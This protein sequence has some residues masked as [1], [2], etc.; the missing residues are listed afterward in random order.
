MTSIWIAAED[1]PS[2]K[3]A[4]RMASHA[5]FLP[6]SGIDA[7]G[8]PKLLSRLGRFN[9]SAVSLCWFVLV[10]LDRHPCPVTLVNGLGPQTKPRMV[11]RI[12]MREI[13]SW[14]LAD[15]QHVAEWLQ[16]PLSKIPQLPDDELDPKQTIVN[17]ARLSKS[18]PNRLGA[19]RYGVG[20]QAVPQ[21]VD[22][23]C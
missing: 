21:R 19:N 15:R 7:G 2:V 14:L 5:G 4:E 8:L 1:L 18:K 9:K 10:D 12:A 22:S 17:L 23:I 20:W 13:E 3:T 11:L 6:Q 16:V